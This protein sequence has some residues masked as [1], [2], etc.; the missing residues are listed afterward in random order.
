MPDFQKDPD[1]EQKKKSGKFKPMK[2]LK[3]LS[4]KGEPGKGQSPRKE[5]SW[6]PEGDAS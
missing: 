6:T 3:R 2:V 4:H 1:S 5:K